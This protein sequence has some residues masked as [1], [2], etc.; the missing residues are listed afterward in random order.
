MIPLRCGPRGATPASPI[1][2]AILADWP[3]FFKRS[4]PELR[5]WLELRDR[6]ADRNAMAADG[7]VKRSVRIAGHATSVS[8]EA[9]FWQA[10]GE[11]AQRRQVSVAALVA[12]IDAE[13]RG[14]L[15]SAIRLFVLDSARC[16]E[17]PK[18]ELT[19]A[20][21]AEAQLAERGA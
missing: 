9:A 7:I 1:A 17:L 11:I 5:I 21:L 10:L 6:R 12:T 8:L 13:R 20:Q 3:D 2:A 16:G 14:G 19:E 15:S 18:P 4:V